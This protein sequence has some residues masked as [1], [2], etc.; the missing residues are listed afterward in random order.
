MGTPGPLEL[1]LLFA[2]VL[3]IFGAKRIPEIARG[4]GKGIREFKDATSEISRELEA[5]GQKRK[6]NQPQAPQQGAPQAREPKKKDPAPQSQREAADEPEPHASGGH[7]DRG[8][9]E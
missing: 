3:L 7:G 9:A 1:L 4:I 2:V 5:E 8:S 6:I